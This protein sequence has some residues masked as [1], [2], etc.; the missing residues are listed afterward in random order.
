MPRR[1]GQGQTPLSGYLDQWDA[2]VSRGLTGLTPAAFYKARF[3]EYAATL[4]SAEDVYVSLQKYNTLADCVRLAERSG[5]GNDGTGPMNHLPTLARKIVD[6][7]A[8]AE[9]VRA[10]TPVAFP[11]CCAHVMHAQ[12]L[13]HAHAHS[14]C[15]A[16]SAKAAREPPCCT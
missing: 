4:G 5:F 2:A 8:K 6:D 15:V 11:L 16:G 12:H 14:P 13:T 7:A 3:C 9:Q 10:H 1:E